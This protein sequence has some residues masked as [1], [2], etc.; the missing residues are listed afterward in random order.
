M[1]IISIDYMRAI[2]M[3]YIVAYWHLFNYTD[4]FPQYNNKLTYNLTLTIL[5][6]FIFISGFLQNK[7]EKSNFYKRKFFRIYPLYLFT[8][9]MFA[10]TSVE[11]LYVLLKSAFLVSLV[12]GPSPLTLW[13]ITVILVL[14]LITPQLQKSLENP[15]NYIASCLLFMAFLVGVYLV[16][17]I[18]AL[19]LLDTRL[20]LY[21]PCYALGLFCSCHGLNSKFIN[22]KSLSIIALIGIIINE[23]EF[24]YTFL[25]RIKQIPLVMSL[26]YL[27]FTLFYVNEKIL[28]KTALI[29]YLSFSSYSMYLLHRPIFIVFKKIYFPTQ[30]PYQILYLY[31]VCFTTIM[32]VS[33]FVQKLHDKSLKKY[34]N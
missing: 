16:L 6:L 28:K 2:C 3:L 29:S 1:R 26:S 33:G 13:F 7:D 25:E 10:I 12:F 5:G 32:L 15:T 11:D 30:G 22:I 19:G 8:I 17:K 14:Y 21:F 18:T 20:I 23:I 31:L 24:S 34:L 4:Y 27:S 9:V